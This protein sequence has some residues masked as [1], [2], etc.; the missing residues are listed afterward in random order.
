MDALVHAV[1]TLGARVQG[2]EYQFGQLLA[3]VDEPLSPTEAL[4]R[5]RQLREQM[6]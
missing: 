2:L 1:E 4:E 3:V 5:L 6:I